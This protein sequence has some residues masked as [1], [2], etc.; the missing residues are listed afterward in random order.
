MTPTDLLR[1]E[2]RVILRALAVLET[3][4][5]RAEAAMTPAWDELVEWLKA[6]AD[7]THHAKEEHA[8]FPAMAAAGVPTEGGPIGVMLA[9]HTEGR[10]LIHTMSTGATAE[11]AEAAR[12]YVALLRQHIDKENDVLFGIAEAVLDGPSMAAL[13]REFER[14]GDRLGVDADIA[15]AETAL[16]AIAAEL[17][18]AGAP[19]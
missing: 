18:P 8:L 9:E 17:R 6:F 11:R 5:A 13:A 16:E 4:A 1:D 15:A 10:A 3:S 19:V 14:I 2:H 12:R 7:R